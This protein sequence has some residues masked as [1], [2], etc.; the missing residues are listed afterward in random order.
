[1]N[2]LAWKLTC[3]QSSINFQNVDDDIYNIDNIY[4][5][6]YKIGVKNIPISGKIFCFSNPGDLIKYYCHLLNNKQISVY[7][8]EVMYGVATD[9]GYPKVAAKLLD[10]FSDFWKHKKLKKRMDVDLIKTPNG[11]ISCSSFFPEVICTV[12][13]FIKAHECKEI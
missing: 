9:I 7:N 1:M 2:V 4:K 3:S 5:I 12:S 10:K 13:S 8:V 6:Y 11:T